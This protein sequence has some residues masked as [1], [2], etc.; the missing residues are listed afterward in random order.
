[1]EQKLLEQMLSEQMLSEQML[2]EQ[3][4]SE[5][6]LSEQMLSEQMLSEQM[7][8][9]QML[10]EQMLLAQMS[11]RHCKPNLH[12]H[13]LKGI[14]KGIV[15]NFIVTNNQF[16]GSTYPA[17]NVDATSNY[18]RGKLYKTSWSLI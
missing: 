2:S 13:Q 3:M 5:Q 10:S 15:K 18:S 7:L 8:L 11:H 16:Q 12:V 17:K 9:A 4:L 1:M 14:Q 6:M